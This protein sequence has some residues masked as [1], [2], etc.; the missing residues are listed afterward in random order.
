MPIAIEGSGF[1]GLLSVGWIP[2]AWLLSAFLHPELLREDVCWSP[3]L[4]VQCLDQ[5]LICGDSTFP[6]FFLLALFRHFASELLALGTAEALEEF[7]S[8]LPWRI[9][10]S[11]SSQSSQSSE[12]SEPSELAKLVESATILLR[13]APISVI[14][15]LRCVGAQCASGLLP[16]Q[17]PGDA[18]MWRR[19][20]DAFIRHMLLPREWQLPLEGNEGRLEHAMLQWTGV[21]RVLSRDLPHLPCPSMSSI[22]GSL[23][24]PR[25]SADLAVCDCLRIDA[26]ESVSSLDRPSR[27][28]DFFFLDL[29]R[30]AEGQGVLPSGLA[31]EGPT[32]RS[33]VLVEGVVSC[34]RALKPT[35]WMIGSV[36]RRASSP[37]SSAASPPITPRTGSFCRTACRRVGRGGP[38]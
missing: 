15:S 24:F 14:Q 6:L 17:L 37:S 4:S 21:Y 13:I 1:D 7:L 27:A 22:A 33:P 10:S 30:A 19:R 3:A 28:R 20:Y 34:L 35:V 9:S 5:M 11:Q 25:F 2:T 26:R 32:W 38:A 23:C 31:A 29:R 8:D 36:S 12:S 16:D 18:S